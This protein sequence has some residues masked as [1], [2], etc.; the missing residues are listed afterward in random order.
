[1]PV[2]NLQGAKGIY[3]FFAGLAALSFAL[4]DLADLAGAAFVS[5]GFFFSA[6]SVAPL[7]LGAKSYRSKPTRHPNGQ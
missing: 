6:I 7:N 2:V 1:M 5:A 4:V 3:F